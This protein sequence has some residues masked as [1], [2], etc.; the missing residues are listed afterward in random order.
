MSYTSI[1]E[2]CDRA[3]ADQIPFWE[4]VMRDD[5][6]E[7]GVT[8]EETFGRMRGMY[9]SMKEAFADY[10]GD[11]RSQSGMAGG[12]GGRFAAYRGRASSLTGPYIGRVVEIALKTSEGNACMRKIVAAPTAGS[13]GVLPAVLIAYETEKGALED[14]LVEALFTAAGLGQV[15]ADRASIA[16]AYGGCQAEI[17][18]AAA[19]ASGALVQLQGGTAGQICDAAALTIKSMTGL[20]CDPVGGLVEVPC[21]KRNAFGAVSAVTGAELAMAGIRSVIPVDEV[22][23]AMAEV[24]QYMP[25]RYKETSEGG[26]A[27][28]P[29]ARTLMERMRGSGERTESGPA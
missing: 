26:L 8:R 12:A 29:T 2:I 18:T 11:R 6:A 4:A 16:G 25:P 13:C 9:R 27:V 21:I 22:I 10:S 24:G 7:R 23:D 15:I 3:A 20:V 14:E 19:M 1:K 17:G 5:M 28:T